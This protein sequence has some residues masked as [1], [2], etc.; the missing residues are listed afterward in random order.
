MQA[1]G[2]SLSSY[3]LAHQ[4]QP[5]SQHDVDVAPQ[6]HVPPRDVAQLAS[7]PIDQLSSNR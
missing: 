7:P 6:Q 2:P 4:P 1:H 3:L 5:L